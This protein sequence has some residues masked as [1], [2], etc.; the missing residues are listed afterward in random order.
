MRLIAS[1]HPLSRPLALWV[2]P[3]AEPDLAERRIAL[4]GPPTD[5]PFAPGAALAPDDRVRS[6]VRAL[7]RHGGYKPTGRGKPSAEYLARAAAE[8][9]LA[10]IHGV[11]DA[12]NAISLASGLCLSAVDSERLVPPLAIEIAPAGASYVFNA[13]G[14][15]IRLDGLLCL[16]D[17]EG[18]TANAVK[19]AQRTKIG[20]ATR[21]VLVVIWGTR[22]LPEHGPAARDALAALLTRWGAEVEPIEIEDLEQGPGEAGA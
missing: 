5:G 4:A 18:P 15:E 17:S 21:D 20:E 12:C 22:E 14:Q 9:Q 6:A 3:G 13:A 11:V 2:R 19:D 10:P 7:L 16:C 8:G 1:P